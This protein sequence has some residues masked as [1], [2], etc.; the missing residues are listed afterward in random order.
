MT[1]TE[2][3]LF[4]LLENISV[5]HHARALQSHPNA[6]F[7]PVE[8]GPSHCGQCAEEEVFSALTDA[9]SW[10]REGLLFT[11]M[12]NKSDMVKPQEKFCL[13]ERILD[14]TRSGQTI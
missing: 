9:N 12:R 2:E 13:K 3:S 7:P 10:T 4:F 11:S 8:Q 1:F 14:L 5:F 6:P